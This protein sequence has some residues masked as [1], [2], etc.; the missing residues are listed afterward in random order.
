[1]SEILYLSHRIPYPPNKGDKIRSWHTLQGLAA[2]YTVHLAT[3]VDDPEDWVHLATVR[4][5]CG[6]TCFRPLRP[7]R[8]RLR[9]LRGLA[10]GEALTV[11]YYRDAGLRRWISDLAARRR[12]DG[13]F[14]YS[15][16]MA[17]Y[18]AD[19]PLAAGARRVLDFCD[20]DS[21]KWRQYAISRR[22]PMRW[23]Y[24]REA[25]LLAEEERRRAEQCDATLVVAETEAGLLRAIAPQ[26]SARIAVLPNGVDT[27]YFDPARS[28]ESPFPPG[29][30]PI[31][32][33]GVMDYYANVDGVR[34]FADDVLPRVR[35]RL[36]D[37]LF[38]I[39][40]S[41]PTAEVK[42]LGTREGIL[43][44]GR[45]P[46]IRP[47]LAH[48]AVVVAPLR[49]AR[50]VQNKVLEALAMA[51]RVVATPNALQ[52]IQLP[53]SGPVDVAADG[54][55]MAGL[56]CDRLGQGGRQ[57]A[58]AR[59]FVLDRYGWAPQMRELVRHMSGPAQERTPVAG[60]A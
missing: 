57:V 47:Y 38:A 25:R 12:L 50:G 18:A 17:R 9:S 32:F 24:A 49:I 33:T 40:G 43:V 52:G 39:V 36:A 34:W 27:D 3:F 56:I 21:D 6:E 37:A 13:V 45:V 8:A 55:A 22:G 15:S 46:D 20:V 19:V 53:V 5:V 51:K 23:L 14:A 41:S 30:R 59:R 54:E 31:V 28:C 10:S 1:M 4:A 2:R 60:V 42:A 16:S 58:E 26:A 35:A 7:L 29:S 48:A 11:A 44:T